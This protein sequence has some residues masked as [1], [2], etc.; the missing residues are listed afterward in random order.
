MDENI[1]QELVEAGRGYESLFVPALFEQW[2]THLIEGAAIREGSHVLDIAC[3]TGVLARKALSRTGPGGRVVGVDPAPGMLA[4]ANEIEPGIDWILCSAEA[5]E[6]DDESFDCVVSQFGM[7]FFQ[8]RQKSVEEMFRV[9]RPGGSLAIA[10][11]NSVEQNPAYADIITV[12]QE[13]VGTD[14][15]DALRLPYSLGNSDEVT[16][17]LG[18]SGFTSINV[19]TKVESAQFPSSRHMVEAELRGWLPLF[20]INLSETKIDDVLVESDSTLS[21]YASSSGKAVFPTSA[22]V[23]TAQKIR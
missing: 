5:L 2:T 1:P 15:A 4:A 3:G 12:L 20:D 16:T 10:I 17:V 7:M 8:D 11:W 14:A 9:L 21:K 19:E 6:L 18:N 13:Q 23:I 22:H